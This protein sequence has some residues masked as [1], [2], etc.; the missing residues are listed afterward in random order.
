MAE[1]LGGGEKR[2]V[3]HILSIPF[4]LWSVFLGVA[5]SLEAHTLPY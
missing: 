3:R 1:L 4:L 2:E 5:V